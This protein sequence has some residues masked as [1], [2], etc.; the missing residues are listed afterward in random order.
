MPLA[1]L[2]TI[3]TDISQIQLNSLIILMQFT[4]ECSGGGTRAHSLRPVPPVCTVLCS[5]SGCMEFVLF[6]RRS[7]YEL[8]FIVERSII[9][10]LNC[11]TTA[12]HSVPMPGKRFMLA[13]QLS[14]LAIKL[15]TLDGLETISNF[16][17]THPP[18]RFAHLSNCWRA[19]GKVS[20]G[21]GEK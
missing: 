2:A 20:A 3:H 10:G 21:V 7:L 6:A 17:Q 4:F 13:L 12:T 14:T 1:A 15:P 19:Y 18:N 11:C 5:L 8:L 16:D 9:D